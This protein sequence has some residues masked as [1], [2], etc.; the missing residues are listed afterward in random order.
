[1]KYPV[2]IVALL[3]SLAAGCSDGSTTESEVRV[4]AAQSA[5]PT[6]STTTTETT[7]ITETKAATPATDTSTTEAQDTESTKFQ[8]ARDSMAAWNTGKVD[9]FLD[10]FT[11]DAILFLWPIDDPHV[12]PGLEFWTTLGDQTVLDECDEWQDGRV[13]CHAIGRD[14]LSGPVGAITDSQVSFWITDG[15]ITKY[16][17]AISD[18]GGYWFIE[19][20]TRWLQS[21]YPEV[22]E[23]TFANSEPCLHHDEYNCWHSWY[24]TSETAAALLEYAPE[25]IAQ[26]EKY[27]VVD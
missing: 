6:D 27:S 25:F 9:A 7:E 8:V 12:R 17:S 5:E 1:M 11:D 26:S 15:R 13:R 2:L 4:T 23:S 24:G 14:D 21:A 18:N 22:W 10:F 3:V 16:S 20:M 19:D